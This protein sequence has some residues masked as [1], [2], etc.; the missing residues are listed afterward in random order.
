MDGTSS[1]LLCDLRW[2]S[3][4]Y[5]ASRQSNWARAGAGQPPEKQV[6]PRIGIRCLLNGLKPPDFLERFEPTSPGLLVA[7]AVIASN[8]RS[9]KPTGNLKTWR[10]VPVEV[11]VVA[12]ENE[13]LQSVDLDEHFTRYPFSFD[14]ELVDSRNPGMEYLRRFLRAPSRNQRADLQRRA[15]ADPFPSP[16]CPFTV[17]T[18]DG[19]WRGRRPQRSPE[20]FDPCHSRAG[21]GCGVPWL[22][23]KW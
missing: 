10:L 22:R 5:R 3:G 2:K 1:V 6:E 16:P 13:A 12:E 8:L 17:F 11:P 7:W 18:G 15:S 23:R 21:R 14:C 20:D 4:R 19:R 9:Q